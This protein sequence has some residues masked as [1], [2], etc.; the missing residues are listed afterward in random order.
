MV[1]MVRIQKVKILNL[2]S[3]PITVFIFVF[4]KKLTVLYTLLMAGVKPG[5]SNVESDDSCQ[6]CHN[7]FP[8]LGSSMS[9][10]YL[11]SWSISGRGGEEARSVKKVFC[12]TI[13]KSF[14][15]RR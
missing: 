2:T 13:K 14:L 12:D 5:F 1:T 11:P 9:P 3:L 8:A 10:L 15:G 7:N 4:S 6:L